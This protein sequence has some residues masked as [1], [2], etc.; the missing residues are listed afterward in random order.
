M[1]CECYYTPSGALTEAKEEHSQANA[2]LANCYPEPPQS[3]PSS[4]DGNKGNLVLTVGIRWFTI[5]FPLGF[6]SAA[7]K[8]K[9]EGQQKVISTTS[10]VVKCLQEYVLFRNK[11]NQHKVNKGFNFTHTKNSMHNLKR[12]PKQRKTVKDTEEQFC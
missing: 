8:S 2:G 4:L 12:K 5:P 11:S 1:N 7:W 3:F 10:T 9:S 6:N